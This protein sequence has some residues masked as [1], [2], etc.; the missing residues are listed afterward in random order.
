[1][2]LSQAE[3][4]YFRSLRSK[5]GRRSEER[6]LLEGWRALGEALDA[7]AGLE[8][9]AVVPARV[10]AP[11][12]EAALR[13]LRERGVS[14]K[15]VSEHDLALMADTVHVQG[16]VALVRKSRHEVGDVLRPGSSLVV[17]LDTVS[18]PGNLGTILRTCDWFGVGGVLLGRG[19]VELYNAK[20]VRATAGSLFHLP[21]AENVALEAALAGAKEAGLRVVATAPDGEQI[22]PALGR[23]PRTV[24][25]LGGEAYGVSP[26]V[27]A[28]G[29]VAVR[30]PRYGKGESLNV[31]VTCGIVLAHLRA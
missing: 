28:L 1:M 3:C 6:F 8:C 25:V 16:V 2:R 17:A 20:V 11:Q 5:K 21:I 12:H 23:G 24:V 15:E 26:E 22:L 14:V 27:R 13:A 29:D 10:R 7:A 4:R 9:V 18:D 19:C 31:A 30:V